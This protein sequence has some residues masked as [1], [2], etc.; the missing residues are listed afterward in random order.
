MLV[1]VG[2]CPDSALRLVRPDAPPMTLQACAGRDMRLGSVQVA[3]GRGWRTLKS[4]PVWVARWFSGSRPRTV[5]HAKEEEVVLH[6][7]STPPPALFICERCARVPVMDSSSEQLCFMRSV[8]D[9]AKE[10]GSFHQC[11][12]AFRWS[13]ASS[14]LGVGARRRWIRRLVKQAWSRSHAVPL[15]CACSDRALPSLGLHCPIS[16]LSSFTAC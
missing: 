10:L 15:T 16:R 4:A 11:A 14:S 8:G 7:S 12:E 9:F 6:R 5:F 1:P 2:C 13:W 3:R